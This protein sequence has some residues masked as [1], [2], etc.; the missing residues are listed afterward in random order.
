MEKLIFKIKKLI[1]VKKIICYLYN[2]LKLLNYKIFFLCFI[3]IYVFE[4]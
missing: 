3:I 4:K 2:V 1:M